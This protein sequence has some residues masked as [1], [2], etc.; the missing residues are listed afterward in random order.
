ML[1]ELYRDRLASEADRDKHISRN[2][3]VKVCRINETENRAGSHSAGVLNFAG[4][5]ELSFKDSVEQAATFAMGTACLLA[6]AS[7]VAAGSGALLAGISAPVVSAATLFGIAYAAKR[8]HGPE[9]AASI[10]RIRRRIEREWLSTTHLRDADSYLL[11]EAGRIMEEH[12][13]QCML[14]KQELAATITDPRGFPVAATEIVLAALAEANDAFRANPDVSDKNQSLEFQFASAI[15]SSA[16]E[17]SMHDFEWFKTFEPHALLEIARTQGEILSAVKD[18]AAGQ[19]QI[20]HHVQDLAA[21]LV[22]E[23]RLEAGYKELADDHAFR[24]PTSTVL[25]DYA[26]VPYLDAS[27]ILSDLLDWLL[28]PNLTAAAGRLYAGAGGVGK[29]RLAIEAIKCARSLEWQAGFIGRA[30]FQSRDFGSKADFSRRLERLVRNSEAQGLLLVV[31]YAENRTNDVARLCEA[32][33]ALEISTPVRIVL[34][35]RTHTGWWGDLRQKSRFA[36]QIFEI[37]PYLELSSAIDAEGRGKLFASACSA[38]ADKLNRASRSG[39]ALVD[40]AW[41]S[42]K[43]TKLDEFRRMPASALL[44]V[45]EAYLHV[46]GVQRTGSVLSEMQR[47]EVRHWQRALPARY[48]SDEPAIGPVL[49]LVH[50]CVAAIT[51]LEGLADENESDLHALIEELAKASLVEGKNRTLG[52][53][54]ARAIEAARNIL[55]ALY[56][57]SDGD[58]FVIEPIRPDILGERVAATSPDS[59]SSV[60]SVLDKFGD[61]PPERRASAAFVSTRMLHPTQDDEVR[62]AGSDAVAWQLLERP[63]ETL[64]ALMLGLRVAGLPLF[65][66]MRS[67]MPQLPSDI[68]DAIQSRCELQNPLMARLCESAIEEMEGRTGDQD[69]RNSD[70]GGIFSIT[71]LTAHRE[72]RTDFEVLSLDQSK[73]DSAQRRKLEESQRLGRLARIKDKGANQPAALEAAEK[74]VSLLAEI[75]YLDPLLTYLHAD[76]LINC[77]RC[78]ASCKQFSKADPMFTDAQKEIDCLRASGFSEYWLKM[79]QLRLWIP[80]LH[81][82]QF[83]PSQNAEDIFERINSDFLLEPDWHGPDTDLIREFSIVLSN[84]GLHL[85]Y[86]DN[87]EGAQ[88]CAELASKLMRNNVNHQGAHFD[89]LSADNLVLAAINLSVIYSGLGLDDQALDASEEAVRVS[90]KLDEIY[91]GQ[92]DALLAK[93]LDSLAADYNGIRRR[94]EAIETATRAVSIFERIGA[95][96]NLSE[97]EDLAAALGNL[98]IAYYNVGGRIFAEMAHAHFIDALAIYEILLEQELVRFPHVLRLI[99]R[100]TQSIEANWN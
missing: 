85:F 37:E 9:S 17:A 3:Q 87:R 83:L 51:L 93:S 40:A 13:P 20:A 89:E 25:A 30:T 79:L 54:D 66:A 56:L 8:K 53:D 64:D 73:L 63:H 61:F 78:N 80:A 45:F 24:L 10:R 33:D 77:A 36:E 91:P 27:R 70:Y 75:K 58:T 62:A 67:I 19:H 28:D 48:G 21:E 74:Q 29:T 12:L 34:L 81:N 46:R 49:Q 84:L 95:R 32:I 39:E 99:A 50:K 22:P 68:L 44:V 59:L 90:E 71:N 92:Y 41:L 52:F 1:E 57:R 43:P 69:T 35:A 38:I 5:T 98:G 100:T 23:L 97:M 42:S 16:F 47:E 15:V 96:T 31:D 2:S 55:S 72:G 4:V 14:D 11:S 86:S 65:E 82:S 76:A 26:I 88:F 60:L 94:P 6:S 7:T 18:V